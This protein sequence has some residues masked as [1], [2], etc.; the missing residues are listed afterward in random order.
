MPSAGS[1]DDLAQSPS[2]RTQRRRETLSVRS[3]LGRI[4]RMNAARHVVSHNQRFR[5]SHMGVPWPGETRP[6]PGRWRRAGE[7]SHRLGLR[8][9]S[10]TVDMARRPGPTAIDAG[11]TGC[12]PR[13][14]QV[15]IRDVAKASGVSPSTVSRALAPGGTQPGGARADHRAYVPSGRD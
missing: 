14:V 10:L 7:E 15:T 1:A 11:G 5:D 6:A 2:P 4:P 13:G 12:Q 8:G 9:P 3:T